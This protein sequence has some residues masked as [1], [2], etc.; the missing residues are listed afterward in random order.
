MPNGTQS[1]ETTAPSSEK[2]SP[3]HLLLRLL[4]LR[5]WRRLCRCRWRLLRIYFSNFWRW[6][7]LWYSARAPHHL[8]EHVLHLLLKH[9]K[10]LDS[11][12]DGSS[13]LGDGLLRRVVFL[14][15]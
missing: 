6:H 3:A 11:G 2:R 5:H 12:S 9:D 4:G 15:A 13:V 7:G 10:L 14:R 1:G 8:C